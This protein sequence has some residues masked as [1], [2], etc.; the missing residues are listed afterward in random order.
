MVVNNTS[1]ILYLNSL[2]LDAQIVIYVGE[3]GVVIYTNTN[4]AAINMNGIFFLQFYNEK[5][6]HN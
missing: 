6:S 2:S 5:D 1:W 3:K 4:Y